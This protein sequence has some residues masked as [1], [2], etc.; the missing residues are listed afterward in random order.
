MFKKKSDLMEINKEIDGKR[1]TVVLI[2]R[3]DTNTSPQ[4]DDELKNHLPS[5]KTLI[6]D[7]RELSYIS[8]AGL[9]VI[10]SMK[11]IMKEQSEMTIIN[12]N[13]TIMEVFEVT[14]FSDI[15]TIK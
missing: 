13:E 6:F 3:L 2:G 4:L 12:V 9:R 8:S 1:M 15:L 7:F 14:G 11:K 10:L 5:L